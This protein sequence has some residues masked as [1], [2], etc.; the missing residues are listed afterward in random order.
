MMADVQT[1][2]AAA[3]TFSRTGGTATE[4]AGTAAGKI[5]K[6]GR[7]FKSVTI[8]IGGIIASAIQPVI[9]WLQK[10]F[11]KFNSPVKTFPCLHY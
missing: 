7:G 9:S 8:E 3:G 4:L 6:L 5:E 2:L 11:D 10:M 1:K